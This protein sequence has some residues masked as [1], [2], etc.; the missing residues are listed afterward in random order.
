MKQTMVHSIGMRKY[1][2]PD[3]ERETNYGNIFHSP[4]STG[5]EIT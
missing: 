5:C 2:T 4:V 1:H 3:N